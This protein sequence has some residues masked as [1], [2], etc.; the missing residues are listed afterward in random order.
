MKALLKAVPVGLN[1][2]FI[3]KF[4]HGF[5]N[6]G[7]FLCVTLKAWYGFKEKRAPKVKDMQ[8]F[9]QNVQNVIFKILTTFKNNAKFTRA[10]C[11]INLKIRNRDKNSILM[12]FLYCHYCWSLLWWN[13]CRSL[14]LWNYTSW[15]RLKLTVQIRLALY[16][17]NSFLTKN[18][19]MA[20]TSVWK[21]IFCCV[22]CKITSKT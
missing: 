21:I 2:K 9:L 1:F 10:A 18:R 6:R 8:V 11:W 16:S 22:E 13:Y 4:S 15:S 12:I 7:G 20:G 19:N 5:T 17:C 3:S 14:M